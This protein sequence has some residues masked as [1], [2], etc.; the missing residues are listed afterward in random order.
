MPPSRGPVGILEL[1]LADLVAAGLLRQLLVS[2]DA[3]LAFRLPR[4]RA[5]AD[6]LQLAL[7]GSLLRLV[8]ASFLSGALRLLLEPARIIALIRNALPAIELQR[9]CRDRVE[10]VAVVGDEDHAAGVVFEVVLQPIRRLGVEMVRRL[11]EQQDVGLREQELRQR[12]ATLFAARQVFHLGMRRRAIHGLQRLFHLRVEIPQIMPVDNVLQPRH[13]VGGLVGI[14]HGQLVIA[15][16]HRL[17]VR[18]AVHG[19]AEHVLCLVE[20]RLLAEIAHAHPVG[21]PG[22]AQ[23]LLL[24]ARHDLQERGLAR[25]VHAHHADLRVGQ[26]GERDVVQH[27]LSAGVGFG[28]LLHDVDV[29]RRGHG[30]SFFGMGL[31]ASRMGARAARRFCDAKTRKSGALCNG[32]AAA[33]QAGLMA[34]KG[35]RA[36]MRVNASPF[37]LYLGRGVLRCN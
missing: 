4:L 20:V 36:K 12:H 15:V 11:V 6:P 9:P 16:E 14:V 32:L 19:V 18:H 24:D 3:R 29:L 2:L 7:Q 1:R 5:G 13:L 31:R 33:A 8:L 26:E 23:E 35:A 17:F 34:L 37:A 10:E 30:V 21:G 25:A 22:L 27:L 28:K